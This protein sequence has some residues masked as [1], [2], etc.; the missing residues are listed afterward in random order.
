MLMAWRIEKYVI[1]GEIDNRVKGRVIGRLWLAGMDEPL[2]LDLQGNTWRDLAGHVLRFVNPKP[3]K[4]LDSLGLTSQQIGFVGDISASRKVRVPTCTD[5]ELKVHIAARTAFP[6]AWGNSLYLEWFSETN[7]RVVIDIAH[8]QLDLDPDRAWEMTEQEEEEQ[9]RANA[10]MLS[11]FVAEMAQSFAEDELEDDEPRS[12]AEAEADAEAAR[13]DLLIDRVNARLTRKGGIADFDRIFE[14]ERERL[15]RERGEPEPRELS[16]EEEAER[17]AWIEE[18]NAIASEALEDADGD[19][20]KE[21][22]EPH[23]LVGSCSDLGVRIHQEVKGN[24]WLD[25]YALEE[26]PLR[27]ALFG[28]QSAAAK[29]AGALGIYRDDEWPPA[30]LFAGDTLVRLKKARG[31][32]RDAIA[33][34]DAADDENLAT[35]PWRAIAHKEIEDILSQVQHLIGEVRDVLEE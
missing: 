8:F 12:A 25:E 2:A 29:L 33:G 7:G 15:R 3:V 1:R 24:G 11:R 17:I 13:M 28:V 19:H 22:S 32:L 4:P 16:P 10:E 6:W 27:I 35:A 30:P 5:E 18:M 14:E 23:P 26:H 34:L 20:W 31:Y 21:D 9:R